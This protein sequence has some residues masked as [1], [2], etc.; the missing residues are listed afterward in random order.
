MRFPKVS[1]KNEKIYILVDLRQTILM[2]S[3]N[4]GER[5][6]FFYIKVE[7]VFLFCRCGDSEFLRKKRELFVG[8]TTNLLMIK[9]NNHTFGRRRQKCFLLCGR[10]RKRTARRVGRAEGADGREATAAEGR[11]WAMPGRERRNGARKGQA[12]T[13]T[14]CG[15]SEGRAG[16]PVTET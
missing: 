5:R 9:E 8:V 6:T 1:T 15:G 2:P 10:N 14:V 16:P 12:T 3:R 4:T 11:A 7:N 13:C